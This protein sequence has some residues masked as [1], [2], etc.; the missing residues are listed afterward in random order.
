[1]KKFYEFKLLLHPAAAGELRFDEIVVW[2]CY[3]KKFE[4]LIWFIHISSFV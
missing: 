4:F 3:I 2:F 1:M